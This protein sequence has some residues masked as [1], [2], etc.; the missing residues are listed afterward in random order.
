[1]R[2]GPE[3][4]L[5]MSERDAELW[6]QAERTSA[7]AFKRR[8]LK[9]PR[10]VSPCDDCCRE[11]AEAMRPDHCDGTYPGEPGEP[12]PN[13]W[14]RREGYATEEERYEARLATMRRAGRRYRNNLKRRAATA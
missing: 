2:L 12:M 9:G 4:P 1:M 11:F 5:C 14:R 3:H 8:V 13:D 10:K 6:W 7:Q